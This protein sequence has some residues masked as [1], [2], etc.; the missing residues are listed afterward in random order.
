[1]CAASTVEMIRESKCMLPRL[2][3][4]LSTVCDHVLAVHKQFQTYI[5]D[6]IKLRPDSPLTDMLRSLSNGSQKHL[7]MY[8]EREDASIFA[9]DLTQNPQHG[10][11]VASVHMAIRTK[12]CACWYIRHLE[13]VFCELLQFRQ[14]FLF[15]CCS[16]PIVCYGFVRHALLA[17]SDG[18]EL[19]LAHGVPVT[20]WSQ[21]K[22]HHL[23]HIAG[24]SVSSVQRLTTK[25]W[26]GPTVLSALPAGTTAWLRPPTN[27]QSGRRLH[28]GALRRTGRSSRSCGKHEYRR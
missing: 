25:R 23:Y 7:A 26:V 3:K 17:T 16:N 4:P 9:F 24:L 12:G 20:A 15:V 1:M 5:T 13:R 10:R 19:L 11:R 14:R 6:L 22:Q 27:E 8:L 21:E 2:F 18:G 28:G